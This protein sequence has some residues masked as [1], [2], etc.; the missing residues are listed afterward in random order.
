MVAQ[1]AFFLYSVHPVVGEDERERVRRQRSEDFAY[2]GIH[3]G[4]GGAVFGRVRAVGVPGVVDAV[5]VYPQDVGHT[6]VEHGQRVGEHVVIGAIVAVAVAGEDDLRIAQVERERVTF[7]RDDAQS[8]PRRHIEERLRVG[9]ARA[10]NRCAVD[11]RRRA[12]D[13]RRRG[14]GCAGR[15]LTQANHR[16]T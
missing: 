10:V 15:I 9:G 2:G 1:A 12:A 4:N 8:C 6:G 7:H 5:E 13:Q 11:G 3:T 16:F 14:N